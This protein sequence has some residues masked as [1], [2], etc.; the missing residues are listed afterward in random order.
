MFE[1]RSFKQLIVIYAL[2]ALICTIALSVF[3]YYTWT[4]FFRNP[5]V[6]IIMANIEFAL[7][8]Y[9]LFLPAKV[10]RDREKANEKKKKE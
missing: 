3:H 4:S 9:V 10:K 6:I 1:N 2:I 8:F 7:I 5:I